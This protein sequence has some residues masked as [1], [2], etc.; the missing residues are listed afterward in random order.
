MAARE[1]MKQRNPKGNTRAMQTF[2]PN[3][4]GKQSGNESHKHLF[5]KDIARND[6]ETVINGIAVSCFPLKRGKQ[7]NRLAARV[8][9]ARHR[10]MELPPCA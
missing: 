10:E 7:G 9:M 8:W 5:Y 2:P 6:R 3:I 1:T 4:A